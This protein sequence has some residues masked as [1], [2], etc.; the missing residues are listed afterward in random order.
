[1]LIY[2]P[3]KCAV[4]EWNLKFDAV[5]VGVDGKVVSLSTD[6]TVTAQAYILFNAWCRGELSLS[7]AMLSQAKSMANQ[8]V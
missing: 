5:Y 7:R 8:D 6:K 2:S 4:G 3:P 1:L